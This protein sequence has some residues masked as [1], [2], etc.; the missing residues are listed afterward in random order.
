MK[1]VRDPELVGAI[2]IAFFA[3]LVLLYLFLYPVWE[4]IQ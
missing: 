1:A 2:V 4:T 3:A